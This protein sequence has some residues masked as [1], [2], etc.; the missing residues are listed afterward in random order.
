LSTREAVVSIVVLPGF[1]GHGLLQ[2][3][4]GSG[5]KSRQDLFTSV[6]RVTPKQEL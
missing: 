4:P 3:L 6:C 5:D 2:I 1:Q